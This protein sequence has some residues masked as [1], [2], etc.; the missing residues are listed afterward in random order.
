MHKTRMNFCKLIWIIILFIIVNFSCKKLVQVN[1]PDDS[2]STAVVFSNDSLAQAAVTGLYIKIMSGRKLLLNG[3]MSL[4]PGLS[5]DELT[6]TLVGDDENEF[7]S[8]AIKVDNSLNNANLWR[9]AYAYIYQCNICVEGLQKSTGVTLEIKKRLTGEVQF[10]RALCYYY[11]VNLYGDVPL[12][13]STKAEINALLPRTPIGNVYNQIERD[14]IA[15]SD[16]L[17]GEKNNTRPTRHAAQSLLARVYLHLKRWDHADAAASAVINSGK[18]ALQSDLDSVFIA[19][20]K[21]TIF[22]LVPVITNMNAVE[23]LIYQPL[24]AGLRPTYILSEGL[25]NA[26]EAGDRRRDHWVRIAPVG[27]INYAYPYKYKMSQSINGEAPKEYNLV[28]R[29]AEQYLVRAEARVHQGDLIGAV[30]D[31]NMIRMRAQLPALS[32]SI[33][34]DE[35]YQA[36][37]QERRIELFTE[38]GHRWFD[39]K[40]TSHANTVLSVISNKDWQPDDQLYPLPIKELEANPN[41]EQNPSYN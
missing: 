31:I 35:C 12:V 11:L 10:V 6:Y 9:A 37:A 28:F 24:A 8:N 21:E 1:E 19:T 22:Q 4:F 27:P 30:G 2:Q 23:G 17:V 41:L 20:S 25:L 34:I 3:G 33:S 15:A 26:F 13:I 38:W 5:A 14:L 18:F 32:T 39:L 40:R 16:A 29:L 7:S 36:V